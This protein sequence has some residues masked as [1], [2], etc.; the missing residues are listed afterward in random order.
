MVSALLQMR[1]E[2]ITANSEAEEMEEYTP[3]FIKEMQE[4]MEQKPIFVGTLEEF[5]KFLDTL[6]CDE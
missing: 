1:K 2:S 6:D 3:E 4:A 5:D